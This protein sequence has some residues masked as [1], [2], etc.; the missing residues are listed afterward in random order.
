MGGVVCVLNDLLRVLC[1]ELRRGHGRHR[2]RLCHLGL[3]L[4]LPSLP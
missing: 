2:C 4:L 1:L 3:V